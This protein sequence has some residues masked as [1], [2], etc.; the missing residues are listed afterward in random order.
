MGEI[1]AAAARGLTAARRLIHRRYWRAAAWSLAL[2]AAAG[3]FSASLLELRYHVPLRSVWRYFTRVHDDVV[4]LVPLLRH[5]ETLTELRRLAP[6]GTGINS[7]GLVYVHDGRLTFHPW[8]PEA[9][10]AAERRVRELEIQYA[11]LV[12]KYL[13]SRL[14]ELLDELMLPE[15]RRQLGRHGFSPTE[16]EA[17]Q[18]QVTASEVDPSARRALRWRVA[19][20]LQA[21]VP[22]HTA[23]YQ[24]ALADKLRFYADHAPPG[25]YLGLFEVHPPE[26]LANGPLQPAD[27]GGGRTLVILP[28]PDGVIE[29]V[30]QAP[31]HNRRYRLLPLPHP[32]GLGL[33]RLA[34]RV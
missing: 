29:I 10:L 16:V 34:V 31:D 15:N 8:R 7:G 4:D 32:G 13:S 20:L 5:S 14:E 11:S 9:A 23:R 26:W 1:G 19:T 30:D 21:F 27:L 33:Y 12:P 6:E 22:H 2:V 3:G 25:Q 18:R 28:R 24:L 17:L